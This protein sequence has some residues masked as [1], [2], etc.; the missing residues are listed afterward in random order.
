MFEDA[1]DGTI[2]MIIGFFVTLPF[3]IWKWVEII[4]WIV[5]H[6]HISFGV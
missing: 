4:V 1:W 2:V 5:K 6:I 3:A